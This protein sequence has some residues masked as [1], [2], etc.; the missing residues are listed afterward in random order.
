MTLQN[1]NSAIEKDTGEKKVPTYFYFIYLILF[2]EVFLQK[3]SI[4]HLEHV[5]QTPSTRGQHSQ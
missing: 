1:K 5:N 4:Q 2:I 3:Y